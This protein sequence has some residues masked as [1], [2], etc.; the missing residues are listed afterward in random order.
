MWPSKR[1]R[2]KVQAA[3]VV[4]RAAAHLRGASTQPPPS[5]RHSSLLPTQGIGREG[6][7]ENTCA[8]RVLATSPPPKT[9]GDSSGPGSKEG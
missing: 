7:L 4:S 9:Q 5:V 6:W 2:D 8:F 3:M 1:E